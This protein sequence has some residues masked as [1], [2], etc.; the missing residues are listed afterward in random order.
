[1]SEL[2]LIEIDE[3]IY[4]IKNSIPIYDGTT[5]RSRKEYK[6]RIDYFTQKRGNRPL[7][8]EKLKPSTLTAQG[9]FSN[10]SIHENVIDMLN[11]PTGDIIEIGSNF[12]IIKNSSYIPPEKKKKSGRGRKPKPKK[13][14]KRQMQGT[15]KYFN[16]Q[17]TFDIKRDDEKPL[18]IKLFRNGVFQVPGVVSPQMIDLIKPIETL[19]EYL[20]ENIGEDIEI[21]EFK[22]VMRNYKTSIVNKKI[23]VDLDR[24][25]D[26]IIKEKSNKLYQKY[27]T[28]MTENL[29]ERFQK[30][31]KSRTYNYNPMRIAEI[32]YNNDRT[33]ALIIKIYKPLEKV[34]TKKTTIKL[35]KK[36]K[37]NFDGGNTEQ[38]INEMYY[39]LEDLYM[40]HSDEI[41][42]N[43]DDIKNEYD[44]NSSSD[45]GESI[46]DEDLHDN[47]SMEPKKIISRSSKY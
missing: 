18:K 34:H 2:S 7:L 4:I 42:V 24:L 23:Y 31:I 17:I 37:V 21:K 46:Y 45:S 12:G 33:F 44:S 29:E 22:S 19:R 16:S 47:S 13:P 14:T 5:L 27:I 11:T 41:L 36:G 8:F 26:I 43:I 1:M 25:E 40:R 32:T 6:K 39:W 9:A 15:G 3:P 10:L 38:E 28:Y 30:I 35:L 20:I